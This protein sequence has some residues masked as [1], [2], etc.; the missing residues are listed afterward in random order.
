MAD[1]TID[2]ELFYLLDQW[3]GVP[4]QGGDLPTGGFTGSSHHNVTTAA[5][6]LGMKIQVLNTS[7]TG[8]DGLSTFIY[9][10]NTEI[11][12]TTAPVR[13]RTW[14][15][16]D[17]TSNWY[18]VTNKKTGELADLGQP[19]AVGLS[20]MS[21]TTGA[22]GWF[23]CGGVCPEAQVT[24]LGGNYVTDST[25]A[26]GPNVLSQLGTTTTQSGG[27]CLQVLATNVAGLPVAFSL[28]ADS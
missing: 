16:C 10:R 25:V 3:P 24:D 19:A 13:A 22:Y 6:P 20:T 5:Y 11:Q 21:T 17:T 15:S 8:A 2:S 28:A 4:W 12:A 9:L 14:V 18:D 7:T 26:A 27:L 1:G 23:W